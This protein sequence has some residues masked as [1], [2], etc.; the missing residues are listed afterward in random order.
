[1][2]AYLAKLDGA[3]GDFAQ[4]FELFQ[5][6]LRGAFNGL[7]SSENPTFPGPRNAMA[8]S[9]R[10]IAE[11]YA[12]QEGERLINRLLGGSHTGVV[13]ALERFKTSWDSSQL[14]RALQSEREALERETLPVLLET[15]T[16]VVE[17]AA[18]AT[19]AAGK[20]FSIEV[21]RAK[22]AT[23]RQERAAAV[24][25]IET[26]KI[27]PEFSVRDAAGRRWPM[28]RH[29]ATSLR[30]ALLR[31]RNEAFM[32]VAAQQGAEI[33]RVDHADGKREVHNLAFS[34]RPGA[35]PGMPAYAEIR[36]RIFHPNSRSV[37]T[38]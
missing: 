25:V 28:Q 4:G 8:G 10:S 30:G 32:N 24:G 36:D 29:L 11:T 15:F 21:Q 5:L 18:S 31:A 12:R 9:V 19:L 2:H 17:L 20:R 23:G 13:D 26:L 6:A 3:V 38:A 1:M 34:R 22:D 37:V 35:I 33:F 16:D 7:T 27:Q 14:E